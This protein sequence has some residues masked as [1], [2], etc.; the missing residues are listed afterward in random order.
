MPS[1]PGPNGFTE[2]TM[3]YRPDLPS[4]NPCRYPAYHT[5]PNKCLEYQFIH[6]KHQEYQ[7]HN[8]LCQYK[9]NEGE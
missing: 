9:V 1:M 5:L 3:L 4:N 2:K 8:I 6:I 7:F